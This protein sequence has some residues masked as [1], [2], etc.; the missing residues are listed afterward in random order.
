MKTFNYFGKEQAIYYEKLNNGLDVYLLPNNNLKTYHISLV[1]KYGGD[2]EEFIPVN[3]KDYIKI[4]DGL[5]H[6]LEHKAFDMENSDSFEFFAKTGTFTNAG[7]NSLYTNYYI[8]GKKQ[9]KKNFNYLLTMVFSPFFTQDTIE[10]EIGIIKEEINMYEDSPEFQLDRT[11][12]KCFF[13]SSFIKSVSGSEESIKTI[14]KKMLDQTFNTFYQPSNMFLVAT[15]KI[16]IKEILDILN[17]NEA[18]NNRLTKKEIIY[19]H[20]KENKNVPCEFKKISS[21]VVHPKIKYGFKF[22]LQDFKFHDWQLLELYLNALFSHLF[23][24]SSLFD[25]QVREKKYANWFTVYYGMSIDGI[26]NLCFTADSDYA[27]LFIE[28]INKVL[29]SIQIAEE[30]LERIKK[31]WYSSIIRSIDNPDYLADIIIDD[32]YDK[33]TNLDQKEMID[34]I[35][36]D[37]LHELIKKL[38]FN[39]KTLVLMLP[40]SQKDE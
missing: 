33:V 6:F 38:D 18:L 2:I 32:I 5:A 1:C 4:P 22:D 26:Y 40:N 19:R 25:E 13:N 12:Q 29:K 28:E 24:S 7:T 3:E 15:G 11:F 36:I 8:S 10:K 16:N 34:K 31:I 39:N 27:D 17:K 37:T 14:N 20:T 23:N 30:D 35:N 21:N 9:F